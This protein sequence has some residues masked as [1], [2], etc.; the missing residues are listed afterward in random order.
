M[1]LLGWDNLKVKMGM[2]YAVLG[3]NV[4]SRREWM[5]KEERRGNTGYDTLLYLLTSNMLLAC[6][7]SMG[8]IWQRLDLFSSPLSLF[9][10]LFVV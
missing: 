3:S 6:M 4:H 7:R 5:E 1:L 10:L 9:R 2:I 8:S